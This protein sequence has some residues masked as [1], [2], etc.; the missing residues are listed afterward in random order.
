MSERFLVSGGG[1][2]IGSHI[3]D[4][5]VNR[6]Q[7]VRVLDDFSTGRRENLVQSMDRIEL[8]EGDIRDLTTVTRAVKDVDYILHHAA[9][10]SVAKSV[11]DPVGTDRSNVLGTVNLLVAARDAGVKRVVY[12]SSTS[13]YGDSPTLPQREDSLTNPLSPYAVS[14][15]AGEN[16]SLAFH[17]VYGLPTVALRYF[18]VYG[19]RQDPAS[20][21]A[22]VIPRFIA[23][24]LK[25]EPLTIYG[26]GQQTRDFVYVAN[27]VEANLLV[28]Q[29][30]SNRSIGQALNIACGAR[31]SLLDLVSYVQSL[32]K[33]RKL[34]VIH[35]PARPGD[36]RDSQADISKARDLI[37][38]EPEVGIE[39]GL[40]KTVEWYAQKHS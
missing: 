6:G 37:A 25:G 39:A 40:K 22:A 33:N 35:E 31:H 16:Y 20:E 14:K 11:A 2:F 27:V 30:S 32:T 36:I 5:L 17:H 19:P 4:E 13:V 15:L 38:Y 24:A 26:D 12:A 7:R 29:P 23:A 3:V 34:E 10:A 9:I 28:C 1:G 18:N 8:V 21:Y